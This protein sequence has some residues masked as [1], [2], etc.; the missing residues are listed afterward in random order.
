MS[1]KLEIILI[2]V[3]V[4]IFPFMKI[5]F[6]SLPIYFIDLFYVFLII[7]Y[8]FQKRIFIDHK[9]I[10]LYLLF[11]F[12]SF[13]VEFTTHYS[14]ISIYFLLRYTLL[15]MDFFIFLKI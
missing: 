14:I 12:F 3:F 11:S 2:S 1:K 5:K 13:L 6:G 4:F 8:G 15:F 7:K 9:F 10:F